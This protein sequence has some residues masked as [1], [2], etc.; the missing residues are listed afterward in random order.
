MN[1]RTYTPLATLAA[2]RHLQ[3]LLDSVDNPDTYCEHMIALGKLL[4]ATIVPSLHHQTTHHHTKVDTLII[5]TAEDA[6]FLQH[7][8]ATE[9]NNQGIT[10]KLA[11]FWNN[12]YQLADHS[13]VAPIVHKFIQSGYESA[14]DIVIVK[15]IM[16]GSCVVRT[17]LIEMLGTIQNIDNIFI[18]APVAHKY[19]EEKLRA[20]FPIDISQKFKFNCFAID[21]KRSKAGEVIPGIGGSVYELL[22]LTDQPVLTAYMPHVVEKLTFADI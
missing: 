14:T 13:S 18:L 7:G 22:G 16:S 15:S 9:L 2:K 20:E 19:S 10:S 1:N 4:A 5:S 17:N 3:G 12:H 6:D 8:V 11:V 21:N